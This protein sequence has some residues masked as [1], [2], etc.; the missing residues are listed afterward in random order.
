MDARRRNAIV[1]GTMTAL[2]AV[3]VALRGAEGAGAGAVSCGDAVNALIPCGTFLV[4]AGA[5]VP[6]D[7]CC[8]GAMA[9]RRMGGTADARRAICRCLE[10]SGPSFGVLPERARLL[11]ARCNISLG[12]PINTHTD[13]NK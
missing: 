9:L 10:Q 13:C 6:S 1:L 11:P 7:S 12:I 4:G 8:R 3:A 2:A 5:A